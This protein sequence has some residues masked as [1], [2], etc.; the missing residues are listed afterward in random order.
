MTQGDVY[1]YKFKEPN[2]NRPVLLLTRTNLI[3]YLNALTVAEIT[4]TIRGNHSEIWLDKLDGMAEEC[5][6]NLANI[7]T[8]AKDK[9]GSYITHLSPEKM[10]ELRKSIEFIFNLKNL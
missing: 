1:W 8:V 7:Q 2:K 3:P 5:A 4:S 9:L 6:V 10:G